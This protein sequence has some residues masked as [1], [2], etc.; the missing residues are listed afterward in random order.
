MAADGC[1]IVS[2]FA[3]A[4]QESLLAQWGMKKA[5]LPLLA[6]AGILGCWACS[7]ISQAVEPTKPDIGEVKQVIRDAAV[8][9]EKLFG[10]ENE[11]AR[12][13]AERVQKLLELKPEA[14]MATTIA[15]KLAKEM[16]STKVVVSIGSAKINRGQHGFVFDHQPEAS[17]RKVRE[18]ES[19][20]PSVEVLFQLWE[21]TDDLQQEKDS[22]RHRE[23]LLQAC[24]KAATSRPE[25]TDAHAML[26]D[27]LFATRCRLSEAE[28]AAREALK[29]DA[30]H[31][32]ARFVIAS[33][34]AARLF[35]EVAGI[36]TDMRVT[37][38]EYF[39]GLL[40]HRPSASDIEK[41]ASHAAQLC[42]ELDALESAASS[43][44][45]AILLRCLA[46][47]Q[48]I[49]VWTNLAVIASDPAVTST[50]MLYAKGSMGM[51][52]SPVF[53]DVATLRK[54]LPLAAGDSEAYAAVFLAW[55]YETAIKGLLS[56]NKAAPGDKHQ[57]TATLLKSDST[58]GK[59]QEVETPDFLLSM[60]EEE[61]KMF[62]E[63]SRHLKFCLDSAKDREAAMIHEAFCRMDI[64]GLY[65]GRFQFGTQH[66]LNGLRHDPIRINL[67][68]FLHMLCQGEFKDDAM[69]A[70][71]FE[72]ML[73]VDPHKK[74]R[75]SVSALTQSL[76]MY[77]R[78]DEL[79]DR[80]LRD[81]P[82][83]FMLWNQKVVFML[84]RDCSEEGIREAVV[85]F[86][87]IKEMPAF[88]S[89][90][91]NNEDRLLFVRNYILF[92]A[93]QGLWDEAVGI[94]ESY[95]KEGYMPEKD[96]RDL[97]KT[98]QELRL[99]K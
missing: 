55:A 10:N 25:D 98:L 80:C 49:E 44:N 18:L 40:E 50:N 31:L 17:R 30:G 69:S 48:F 7:N 84:K 60:P 32:R 94:T 54:A 52:Q 96:A 88:E 39:K 19:A 79:L 35:N 13:L 2:H 75:Q 93:M 51:S 71:T 58:F 81:E 37:V 64:Y 59:L 61:R 33:I 34:G 38:D 68:G 12:G 26:A 24:R 41:V 74:R 46:L 20:K 15:Q 42:A 99:M 73:A 77:R 82:D 92:Q 45:L 11:D 90:A 8:K 23:A 5:R 3:I 1:G 83:D 95:L 89:A 78:A 57:A 4:I 36:E 76:G 43:S 67:L 85:I 21:L 14:T 86:D 70:A 63:A 29:R 65:G 66:L 27:A 56:P 9:I 6:A 91:I 53:R 62:E 16:Q 72:L 22:A 97:L 47:R 28:H 87:K